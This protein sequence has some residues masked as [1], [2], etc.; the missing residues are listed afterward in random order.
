MTEFKDQ[1]SPL[2]LR[3][4]DVEYHVPDGLPE[5][6][7]GRGEHGE[8]RVSRLPIVLKVV[9]CGQWEKSP[10]RNLNRSRYSSN[11]RPHQEHGDDV[12]DELDGHHSACR[13]RHE[14]LRIRVSIVNVSVDVPC[15]DQRSNDKLQLQNNTRPRGYSAKRLRD[16]RSKS[17]DQRSHMVHRRWIAIRLL[18]SSTDAS[19]CRRRPLCRGL[20]RRPE[21]SRDQRS[22]RDSQKHDL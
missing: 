9:W 1:R 21:E 10:R 22:I 7:G 15:K 2:T 16:R 11:R 6:E 12:H 8:D 3:L 4:S 13:H 19:L 18:G 17:K 20:L 14:I 5:D